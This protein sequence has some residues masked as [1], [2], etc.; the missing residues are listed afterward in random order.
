MEIENKH[1]SAKYDRQLRL[2]GAQGQKILMESK[3]CLLFCEPAGVETLKNLILPGI[4]SVTIVDD[5]DVTDRDLGNNFF[6]TEG[7]LGK[8]RSEAVKSWLLELN[9]DVNGE[10]V[11]AH[12]ADLLRDNPEFLKKFN[13][14]I[15]SE[16]TEKLTREIGDLCA[17]TDISLIVFRSSGFLGS[18]RI[19]DQIHTIVEGKAERDLD[20]YRLSSPFPEFQEYVNSFD[21][22]KLDD[23]QH[24]HVPYFVLLIRFLQQ[25]KDQNEGKAPQTFAE[26]QKFGEFIKSKSRNWLEEENFQEAVKFAHKAFIDP[27]RVPDN[28]DRIFES[29]FVKEVN[30]SSED[31]WILSEALRRFIAKN[32]LLPV[33]SS[34]PD[35]TAD[36]DNYL[37][38]KRLFEKK[39]E[40]DR[41]E[42]NGFVKELLAGSNRNISEEDLKTFVENVFNLNFIEY[43]T[44]AQEYDSP[45]ELEVFE[46][47]NYKWHFALRANSQFF[48]AYNRW[49]SL[50]TDGDVQKLNE[51]LTSLQKKIEGIVAVEE[52]NLQ[53]CQELARYENSQLHTIASFLG[54][55]ASQEAI[56]LLTHQFKPISNTYV[57]NGI[58]SEA[59]VYE[60]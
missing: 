10:A 2:W 27:A 28:L 12:P 24:R 4:G 45:I 13:L 38:L 16:T 31:F 5:Q 43:R 58:T 41:E 50:N 21:L 49:P 40:Q 26:K 7:D 30:S 47:D 14:I 46:T 48:E 57:F 6:I 9:P 53:I 11:V 32:G 23:F 29:K 42:L 17:Q 22:Q 36:T 3:V 20:S 51:I 56:K 19:Y 18:V 35:V 8:K 33:R 60:F 52:E 34:I 44:V 55:V 39:A 15:L 59:E 54:G 37:K 25:W 1:Q